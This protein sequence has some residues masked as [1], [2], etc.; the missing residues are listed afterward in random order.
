MTQMG[1]AADKAI[2]ST[3]LAAALGLLASLI[4]TYAASQSRLKN[5][6]AAWERRP[7]EVERQIENGPICR[8]ISSPILDADW[9]ALD[10][11]FASGKRALAQGHWK[12][13]VTALKFAALRDPRNADIQNFIGY[14]YRQLDQ[15]GPAMGHL[16]QALL[17][18][19]HHR[20]AHENLGELLL[21]LD[22]PAQAEEHLVALKEICLISCAEFD[23]LQRAIEIDR[24]SLIH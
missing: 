18:N 24:H 20:G 23:N 6:F 5:E 3:R 10:P 22:E 2:R 9:A 14:A 1:A 17:L 4:V 12:T 8:S 11:D 16:Q 13:A 7:S 19:P 21:A 15:L